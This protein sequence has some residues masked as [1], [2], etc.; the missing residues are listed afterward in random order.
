LEFLGDV[1]DEDQELINYLQEAVGY[2]LTGHTRE[3]C[4]FYLC[5]PSR[6]GK[7]IFTET[8]IHMFGREPLATEADFGTFSRSRDGDSQNF[9]MAGLKE[10]RLVVA[11]EGEEGQ[12]LN[13][14]R[15]KHM[16]GGNYIRCAHKFKDFFNYRPKFKVWLSSNHRLKM[17]VNDDAAWGRVRVIEFPNSYL[18]K[19]NKLLKQQ[20]HQP[21]V[22]RGVLAWAVQG[23]MKWYARGSCGLDVPRSV[24]STTDEARHGLDHVRRWLK[25]STEEDREGFVPNGDLYVNYA[26]WCDHNGVPPMSKRELT[27]DLKEKGYEAGKQKW[28]N[29][30]NGRG[31]HGI[32]LKQDAS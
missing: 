3:E 2:T 22:L 20:M 27:K 32:T 15:I 25:A 11:S 23:S 6:S 4:L 17:S 18:G 12:H 16:T 14:A 31:C 7:G 30:A 1:L 8:L 28:H 24:Q 10:C 9:D 26:D 19:E 29:G 5:G 13:A 21:E